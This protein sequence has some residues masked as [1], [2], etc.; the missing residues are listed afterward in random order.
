VLKKIQASLNVLAR[1]LVKRTCVKSRDFGNYL[2]HDAKNT[3][4]KTSNFNTAVRTSNFASIFRQYYLV[5]VRAT[6]GPY[7]V[8]FELA[9]VTF[10][11]FPLFFPPQFS[12]SFTLC[13]IYLLLFHCNNG[14]T[15]TPQCYVIRTLPVVFDIQIYISIYQN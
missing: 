6:A 13:D 11:T 15:N 9:T 8:C 2:S 5:G 4:Q 7:S 14:C 3:S 12:T 1:R 10:R